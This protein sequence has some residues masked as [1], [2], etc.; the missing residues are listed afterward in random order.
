M[1]K[2]TFYHNHLQPLSCCLSMVK[3]ENMRCYTQ[4]RLQP[5]NK[6]STVASRPITSDKTSLTQKITN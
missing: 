1:V 5:G 6:K 3:N 2:C 4:N